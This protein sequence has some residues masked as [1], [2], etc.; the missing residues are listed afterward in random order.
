MTPFV[1]APDK[2]Q[3]KWINLDN[4]R[5][6]AGVSTEESMN[7]TVLPPLI[8]ATKRGDIGTV[9]DLLHEGITLYFGL[10]SETIFSYY[11]SGKNHSYSSKCVSFLVF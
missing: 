9:Q 1:D 10:L 8:D 2:F 11:R 7:L 5:N 3:W 4:I 6:M